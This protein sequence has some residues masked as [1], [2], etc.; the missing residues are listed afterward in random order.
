MLYHV[1]YHDDEDGH[2]DQE[3]CVRRTSRYN[4]ITHR[5][6][7]RSICF[8][9]LCD[10]APHITSLRLSVPV[11]C[12]D[13]STLARHLTPSNYRSFLQE[14]SAA[15]PRLRHLWLQHLI[16]NFVTDLAQR[17]DDPLG[18]FPE[19]ERL[20]LVSTSNDTPLATWVTTKRRT[21]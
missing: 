20:E 4:D 17:L 5:K 15:F 16:W 9:R 11:Y 21:A 3:L 10:E 19:L 8:P 14:I 6:T 7:W 1:G 12:H 18:Y 2:D 13:R